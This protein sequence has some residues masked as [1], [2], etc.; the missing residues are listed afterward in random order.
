ML[1]HSQWKL[2][3]ITTTELAG[4]VSIQVTSEH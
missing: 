2:I 4:S 1:R 3:Y